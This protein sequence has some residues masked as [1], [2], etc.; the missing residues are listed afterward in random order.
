MSD[1]I[2][3]SSE[4]IENIFSRIDK[5]EI[6]GSSSI[7]NAWYDTLM[8]IK[9]FSRDD[10]S[11]QV[12]NGSQLADHSRIVD[13]KNGVL[14]VETDH[15]GRIQMFNFYSKYILNGIKQ[16]VPEL[17]INSIAYKLK[18]KYE[19]DSVRQRELTV[20]ELDKSLNKRLNSVEKKEDFE[21]NIQK[22][23]TKPLPDELKNLFERLKN[24]M[25]S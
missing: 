6:A 12:K 23:E 19:K 2:S 13:L 8:S 17:K 3:K 15:P 14:I 24:S 10:T 16:K 7:C 22:D 18:G 21:K 1:S 4:I 9:S 20:D 5:N 11:V 25:K